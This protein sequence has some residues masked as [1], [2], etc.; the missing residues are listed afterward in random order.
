MNYNGAAEKQNNMRRVIAIFVAVALSFTMLFSTIYIAKEQH[1]EC[2]GAECPVCHNIAR[3]E[4]FLNHISTGLIHL[5]ISVVAVMIVS[6]IL[7]KENENISH[8]TL[9]S[10][11]VRLDN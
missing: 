7:P 4:Q 1:H 6:I 11:K 2:H 10:F 8:P 3:C 5:A 9:V